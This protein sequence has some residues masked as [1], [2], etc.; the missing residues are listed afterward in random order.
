[1][2]GRTRSGLRFGLRFLPHLLLLGLLGI[3]M[4]VWSAHHR[5]EEELVQLSQQGSSQER[6]WALHVLTNRAGL[7]NT[8][9]DRAYILG[10]LNDPDPLVADFPYTV[11]VCRLQPPTWQERRMSA[12]L[13]PDETPPYRDGL[14]DWLRRYL[15][16]RRKVGGAPYGAALRLKMPE[17][18]WLL[19][20]M[21]GESL[22]E[23]EVVAYLLERK[24]DA[25]SA[26][27][28]RLQP[29]KRRQNRDGGE[30]PPGR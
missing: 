9:F 7:A 26:R 4:R 25:A 10:L 12:R 20:V 18:E 13:K 8:K 17:L 29:S 19:A 24:Q 6:L 15:F 3:E 28:S 27:G 1:M 23:A 21:D 30:L 14:L 2:S 11:D 5:T 16:Y 22:D